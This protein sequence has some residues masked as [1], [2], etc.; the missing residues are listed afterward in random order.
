MLRYMLRYTRYVTRKQIN[1][2]TYIFRHSHRLCQCIVHNGL[3]DFQCWLNR[4]F[5]V[6]SH[7]D[8]LV[9]RHFGTGAEVSGQFTS[10]KV[11]CPKG[12]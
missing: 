7:R 2:I 11:T 8:T 1:D 4:S 6:T 12:H 10:L 9:P 5:M 3:W